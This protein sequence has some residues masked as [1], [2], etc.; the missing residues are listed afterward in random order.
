MTFS[1]Q[2]HQWDSLEGPR[3]ATLLNLQPYRLHALFLQGPRRQ[4]SGDAIAP[5]TILICFTTI[6]MIPTEGAPTEQ[7]LADQLSTEE[8]MNPS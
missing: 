5:S 2:Q 3:A 6:R 1:Q 8:G 4:D 7:F